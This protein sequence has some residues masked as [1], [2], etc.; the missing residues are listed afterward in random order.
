MLQPGLVPQGAATT[1]TS[2]LPTCALAADSRPT[3]WKLSPAE[4]QEVGK[5]NRSTSSSEV[6]LEHVS[7]FKDDADQDEKPSPQENKEKVGK[8]EIHTVETEV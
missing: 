7:E 5:S 1:Q 6:A 4:N 3:S 2:A 8:E